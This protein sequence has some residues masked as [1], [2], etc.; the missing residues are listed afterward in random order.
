MGVLQLSIPAP[1]DG[2]AAS[3]NTTPTASANSAE[4]RNTTPSPI[5]SV[6]SSTFSTTPVT[7]NLASGSS[8]LNAYHGQGIK[9]HGASLARFS[10]NGGL[11]PGS[12]GVVLPSQRPASFL[13]M[14]PPGVSNNTV[15]Y[16]NHP[17]NLHVNQRGGVS[18][19]A[20]TSTTVLSSMN[21]P[22]NMLNNGPGVIT[23]G[24]RISK[25]QT[26]HM[27]STAA[28][29]GQFPNMNRFGNT[30]STNLLGTVTVGG[31]TMNNNPIT[32][33]G[34]VAIGPYGNRNRL[35]GNA[36]AVA[37]GN[38][39]NAGRGDGGAFTTNRSS[40]SGAAA[41][42][43]PR[44]PLLPMTS[45]STMTGGRMVTKER[46]LRRTQT[47]TPPKIQAT[48]TTPSPG[49]PMVDYEDYQSGH[50]GVVSTTDVGTNTP[51]FMTP[52]VALTSGLITLSVHEALT[53]DGV[54]LA[55]HPDVFSKC[56]GKKD[57]KEAKIP[58]NQRL[59]PGDLVEIRVWTVRPGIAVDAA[60]SQS[61]LNSTPGSVLKPKAKS[62]VVR[63]VLHSR[64]TSLATVNSSISN[65][66]NLSNSLTIT[67]RSALGTQG[68]IT[69]TQ[70]PPLPMVVGGEGLSSFGT[71]P[72]IS[73][74]ESGK[75]G[76]SVGS[77]SDEGADARAGV[78]LGEHLLEMQQEEAP[79]AIGSNLSS[80]FAGATS[81]L[82]KMAVPSAD[83][84]STHLSSRQE[85]NSEDNSSVSTANMHSRDSS[86][87]TTS[88]S[89]MNALHSSQSRE[90]P[91]ISPLT[92][93]KP[94]SEGMPK[95]HPLTTNLSQHITNSSPVQILPMR[96]DGPLM[97]SSSAGPLPPPLPQP[98]SSATHLTKATKGSGTSTP[99]SHPSS[100]R[101]ATSTV[102][103]PPTNSSSRIN[104]ISSANKSRPPIAMLNSA[105]QGQAPTSSPTRTPWSFLSPDTAKTYKKSLLP[106]ASVLSPPD[107]DSRERAS[108]SDLPSVPIM[109][110]GETTLTHTRNHSIAMTGSLTVGTGPTHHRFRSN[111]TTTSD[112]TP[113]AQ[114]SAKDNGTANINDIL[115]KT[116]FVKVS[117]IMPVSDGTL[118]SIKS[119]ARTQVSLLRQVADLY[120]ITSYDT[121]T[122]TQTTRSNVPVVQQSISADFLTLTFKDQFVS[123]GDMYNFQNE[124]LGG[125]V[126]E[127]KRLMFNG[128]R[129]IT[130]VIRHD[131]R[132]I[133]SGLI[134]EDT[135]LTFRS[136]SARI[137]WLIQ[138][139]S[140]MYEFASPN[141]AA[142]N[143]T[144]N[145][146]SSSCKIYFDKLIEFVRRL[147]NKWKRLQ[148]SQCH[149]L[150][151][152]FVCSNLFIVFTNYHLYRWE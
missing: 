120:N 13:Q 28:N 129:T 133:R 146:S 43:L 95:P 109:S 127:S 76:G 93:A 143:Q 117:F 122:V 149:G 86:L 106:P 71:S 136:R 125:W 31:T 112:S 68:I 40:L 100:P 53:F 70:P 18:R 84:S 10:S 16:P 17:N 74:T 144:N 34:A 88:A 138:M 151:G 4:E 42:P 92:T 140:E 27:G 15:V 101:N 110:T 139:S 119:G 102:S 1:S 25:T 91:Q 45:A 48:G 7:S 142:G 29:A 152:W 114:V 66:S 80:V 33:R 38:A 11:P 111:A 89:W 49:G 78:L 58:N 116:H 5:R 104:N 99:S 52:E 55:L 3:S 12:N 105:E 73:V 21:P 35:V 61:S 63:P 54:E 37:M 124:V 50:G 118:S 24:G 20:P 130:K 44:P 26:V 97:S 14:P 145:E 107:L 72:N 59:R 64:N 36:Q 69:S 81:S 147:F 108:T 67:P 6:V 148:V 9:H 126:Y 98:S 132:I 47:S 82:L 103:T 94:V 75:T 30:Q 131:D 115:Q 141:E 46:S 65:V 41:P 22:W 150:L 32:N 90:S 2:G 128:I 135:K 51:V 96:R 123:R 23:Q 39:T 85:S 8:F 83:L 60:T 62:S 57:G 134:S 87:L 121:V 56:T 137:I 19:N 113:T 77:S 79:A